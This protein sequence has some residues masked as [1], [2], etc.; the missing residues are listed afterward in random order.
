MTV[1]CGFASLA[2]DAGAMYNAKAEIQRCADSA[3]LAAAAELGNSSGDPL[4]RARYVAPQHAALNT[5]LKDPILLDDSDFTFGTAYIP[6][7]STGKYV[8]TPTNQCPN[9]VRVRVRRT[10]DLHSG[11]MSLFFARTFNAADHDPG[12]RPPSTAVRICTVSVGADS[13]QSLM[14]DV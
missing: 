5:V 3:A 7:Q 14:Q 13:D 10:Q 2:I 4:A 1:F 6:D 8:F 12:V 11:P 9:S